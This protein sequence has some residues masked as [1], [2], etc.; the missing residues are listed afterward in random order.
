MPSYTRPSNYPNWTVGNPGVQVQPTSGQQFAGYVANQRPSP[1]ILNWEL[2]NISDWINWLDQ[3]TQINDD[4]VTYDAVVGTNGTFPDINTLMASANIA[5]IKNVLV[6]TLQTV[7]TTQVIN[8]PDMQFTFKPQ[9]FYTVGLSLANCISI[10][11]SRVRIIGGRFIGFTGAAI[12]VQAG[13]NNCLL[14]QI[15]FN[16]NAVSIS[17]LGTNTTLSNNVEEV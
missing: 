2:G 11:A 8:Q 6:S 13:A 15:Y 10:T 1:G 9:A 16:G 14:S 3:Q 17:D 7:T 12:T 4:I 5:N